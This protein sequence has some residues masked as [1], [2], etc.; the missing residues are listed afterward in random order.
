[1]NP[2]VVVALIVARVVKIDARC[3]VNGF[4]LRYE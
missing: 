3:F 1:M 2:G 4:A